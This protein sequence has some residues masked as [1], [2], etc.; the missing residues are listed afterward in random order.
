MSTRRSEESPNGD[1]GMRSL[2][3]AGLA[4]EL[5]G[6]ATGSTIWIDPP[7][8]PDG[9]GVVVITW[10]ER[11][12]VQGMMHASGAWPLICA[13]EIAAWLE[14]HA[15]GFPYLRPPCTWEGIRVEAVGYQPIAFA[16]PVEALRKMKSAM[17]RPHH[18][19]S[20]LRF[21]AGMPRVSPWVIHCT[22][23]DGRTIVHL[24]LSLHRQT[25][26]RWVD[27]VCA[28]W[29]PVDVVVS[30]VDY[31][32]EEAWLKLLP[33]FEAGHY[34]V[35]DLLGD[36]RRRIG[37]PAGD[38]APLADALAGRGIR[39]RM[40]MSGGRCVVRFRD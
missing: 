8:A 31:G 22:L 10:A 17:R 20:R 36:V 18:A 38:L 26:E 13:P 1:I 6:G 7:R 28:R 33:R 11:E 16:T 9:G 37:L 3:D 25:P 27:E 23:P 15:P 12:R 5:G 35:A 32:E 29:C 19:L 40:L 30:G 24:N 14:R 39:A 2:G 4:V 21:R 34:I